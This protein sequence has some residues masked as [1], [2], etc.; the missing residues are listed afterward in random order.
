VTIRTVVS[1]DDDLSTADGRAVARTIAA[2]DA[3]EA[4][5]SSERI[6][7]QKRQRSEKGEWHG[8]TPP[9]GY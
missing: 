2:W 3:A 4:E 7:R 8:G 5:R 9:Y 1:G 6:K